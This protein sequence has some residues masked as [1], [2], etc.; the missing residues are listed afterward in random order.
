[1]ILVTG[2]SG[3]VGSEVVKELHSMGE[4]VRAGYH[5]RR[6]DLAGVESARMDVTTGEGIDAAL[7]GV[8]A[9]FLLVGNIDDQIAAESRV[10]DAARRAGVKRIVKLSVLGAESEAFAY[11]RI[12]RPIERAIEASGIPYTHLR[13]AGFMQN[14]LS[15]YRDAIRREGALR[16]PC[17]DTREAHVDARDIARVAAHALTRD[18]HEG[19]AYDLCGPEAL[20]YADVAH[21]LSAVTGKPIAYIPIAEDEFETAMRAAAAPSEHVNALLELF[22]FHKA[23]RAAVR[24][25]AIKDVTGREPISFDEFARDHASWWKS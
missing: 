22:R 14:F 16:L 19:K 10:V 20:T 21:E 15:H 18:G 24:S 13:P 4:R 7:E 11:A 8:E 25:T 23:G 9:V 1:M 2:A 17:G 6:S 5:S 12:H 3:T